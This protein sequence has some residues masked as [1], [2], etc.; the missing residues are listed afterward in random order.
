M[1]GVLRKVVF[2]IGLS[3][4]VWLERAGTSG[5]QSSQS[6]RRQPL[7]FLSREKELT[8]TNGVARLRRPVLRAEIFWIFGM[9]A[10][11][12]FVSKNRYLFHLDTSSFCTTSEGFLGSPKASYNPVTRPNLCSARTSKFFRFLAS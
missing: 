12:S 3:G 8:V 10:R 6:M 2:S 5:F 9:D 7:I 11:V 4:L 1:Y